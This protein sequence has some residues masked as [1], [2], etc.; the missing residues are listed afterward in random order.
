MTHYPFLATKLRW[1]HA[2][3]RCL[4]RLSSFSSA[5]IWPTVSLSVLH[6]WLTTYPYYHHH[7]VWMKHWVSGIRSWD[8]W[9]TQDGRTWATVVIYHGSS[10][11]FCDELDFRESVFPATDSW[12]YKAPAGGSRRSGLPCVQIKIIHHYHCYQ[13]IMHH[14][15]QPSCPN[16]CDFKLQ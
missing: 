7:H 11:S 16:R 2:L 14:L 4:P 5:S 6:D 13:F 1:D 8:A 9:W 10:A 12:L 15:V 3:C